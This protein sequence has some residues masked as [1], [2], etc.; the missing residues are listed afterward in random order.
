MLRYILFTFVILF[1]FYQNTIIEGVESQCCTPIC[2]GTATD[3]SQTCDLD[4]ST[5]GSAA[6]PA[7]CDETPEID[8]ITS[9]FVNS[10]CE[11]IKDSSGDIDNMLKMIKTFEVSDPVKLRN[12]QENPNDDAEKLYDNAEVTFWCD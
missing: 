8:G 11:S 10:T 2:T 12:K 5:D 3:T 7:G 4:A 6:C 1:I 9:G